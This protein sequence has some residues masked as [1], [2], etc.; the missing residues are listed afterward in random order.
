MEKRKTFVHEE[1]IQRTTQPKSNKRPAFAKISFTLSDAYLIYI[2]RGDTK[3]EKEKQ[4]KD[5]QEKQEKDKQEKQEKA[6]LSKEKEGRNSAEEKDE[7]LLTSPKP[8]K[9]RMSGMKAKAM[10]M[11]VRKG[12]IR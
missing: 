12:G 8:E 5:K 9:K 4:E 11:S 7:Q 3:Q 6:E 10:T 2:F 1:L